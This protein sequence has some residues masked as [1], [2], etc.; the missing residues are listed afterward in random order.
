[1]CQQNEYKVKYTILLKFKPLN[2]YEFF[3]NLTWL[4]VS[5]N[6]QRSLN[7]FHVA[8]TKFKNTIFFLTVLLIFIKRT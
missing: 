2:L 4:K 6:C 3:S 8:I 1:M 7:N 5:S